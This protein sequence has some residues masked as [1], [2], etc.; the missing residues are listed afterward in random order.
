MRAP[1]AP[2][3][4]KEFEGPYSPV[5]AEQP[6]VPS[7]TTVDNVTAARPIMHAGNCVLDFAT[8]NL[9]QYWP[10]GTTYWA[11]RTLTPWLRDCGQAALLDLRWSKYNHMDVGFEDPDVGFCFSDPDASPAYI[12]DQ[13]N[14]TLIDSNS[15]PHSFVT[16]H[17]WEEV[18]VLTAYYQNDYARVPFDLE[19]IR[20]VYPQGARVCYRKSDTPPSNGPWE[21]ADAQGPGTDASTVGGWYCWLHLE[22]GHWVLSARADDVVA[23]KI[24]GSAVTPGTFAIDDIHGVV[25]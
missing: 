7:G 10:G 21:A 5:L 18:L 1:G 17:D 3:F 23:G 8:P 4:A 14:C 9:M 2:Q 13:G 6:R 22:A 20:I 16:T 12:D 15:T 24:T 11:D 25:H 19:R